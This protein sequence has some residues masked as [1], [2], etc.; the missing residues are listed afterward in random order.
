MPE[1]NEDL[2]EAKDAAQVRKA[3]GFSTIYV[4]SSRMGLSPWDIRVTLG[5][6]MEI[7]AETQVNEDLVTVVMSPQHAKAVLS[8]LTLV[9]AAYEKAFGDLPDNLKM[10]REAKAAKAGKV[11]KVSTENAATGKG[12]KTV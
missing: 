12:K 8:S 6:V 5:Q 7:D 10:I 3:A 1:S 11:A 9:V 4:N 2:M